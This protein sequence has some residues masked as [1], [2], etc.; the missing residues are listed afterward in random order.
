VLGRVTAEPAHTLPVARS[1]DEAHARSGPAARP[2]LVQLARAA[3]AIVIVV[4]AT[5][6]LVAVGADLAIACIALLLAVVAASALGYAA[7]ALAAVTAAAALT[8]YFTP[9]LHSFRIDR[10][11]DVLALVAFVTVSV[12]VGATVAR[13]NALRRRSEL[14]TREA[15]LRLALT[16]ELASG[17]ETQR[18]LRNLATSLVELFDLE[19]CTVST[20]GSAV[21][22]ASARGGTGLGALDVRDRKLDLHLV[23]ARPLS[24][25]EQ[26]TIRALAAGLATALDRNRLDREAAEQRMRADLDRSRASFLT[27]VTHDL[28]TPLATIKTAT[29][30]LLSS[31]GAVDGTV[32]HELLEMAYDEA[33]RLEGL[34]TKVLE[35]ARI[36][37]GAVQP[38]PAA[39]AVADLVRG[40]VVRL[41]PLA[42]ARPIRLDVDAE[43]PPVWVDATLLEHVVTNLLENAIRHDPSEREIEVRARAA[44]PRVE[45]VVS[46]HGVGI[47]PRDRERVF[48]E[49]VRLDAPTD[50]PGTGLGLA[51]VRAFTEVN[52][53]GVRYQ[54]TPGG[55]ATFVLGLPT[56]PNGGEE[57]DDAVEAG[58]V[59]ES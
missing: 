45:V 46:D 9:P 37:S 57:A 12:I 43:L 20:D 22:A 30:T 49:F 16:N 5:A 8:Y 21:S 18:V 52:G 28:R 55:G 23:L 53:G 26:R 50:G 15:E 59:E 27:A 47:A 25:D 54:T 40:A 7:G 34:V 58:E 32:Q 38:E 44:G 48:E 31:S 41:G 14:A 33:A 24:I 19:R 10:T 29:G 51:I 2:A 36:R 42:D 13:L 39:V 35:V 11:D 1:R 56:A 17:A 6:I 3:L 4:V